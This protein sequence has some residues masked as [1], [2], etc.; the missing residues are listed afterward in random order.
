MIESAF[1][2]PSHD[3]A[4]AFRP[5]LD[6]MAN[7]GRVLHFAPALSSP[8]GLSPEAAA[9]AVTLCDFQ[10]SIW[11]EQELRTPAIE[12][13]LRF[14]AGAPLTH[15]ET[16]AAFAFVDALYGVP[17][18]SQFSKGT[19]EYPD[20]ST[21]IVIQ[22]EQLRSDSGVT[23]RGPGI[24]SERRLG[25]VSLGA[26]FWQQMIASRSDFPLGIDVIFVA[27]GAIAA[28]PR[29]TQILFLEIV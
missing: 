8:P 29:S 17:D 27:P 19:H 11:L 26:D 3:M 10:T 28:I 21:T 7:P 4:R 18:L 24:Q 15:I 14:H 5:I 2:N 6:A 13:Y 25:S 22:T 23:L 20:R 16:D 12:H 1:I 9:V